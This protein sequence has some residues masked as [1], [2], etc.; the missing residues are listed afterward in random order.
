[1][2]P[3]SVALI[4]CVAMLCVTAIGMR[5]MAYR[6]RRSHWQSK[7]ILRMGNELEDRLKAFDELKKQVDTLSLKVG[8]R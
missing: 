2:I 6:F 1:M 3:L 4:L 8:I 5:E 7:D